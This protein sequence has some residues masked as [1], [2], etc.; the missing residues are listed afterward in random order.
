MEDILI[1]GRIYI[2]RSLKTDKIYIGST[3]KKLKYRLTE[4]LSDYKR[5]LDENIFDTTWRS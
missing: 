5:Y 1:T 4:H 3:T 2:L